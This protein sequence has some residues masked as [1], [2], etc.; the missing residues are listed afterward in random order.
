LSCEASVKRA[1]SLDATFFALA[2]PTRRAILARLT[3]GEASVNELAEPFQ[4]S[5]PAISSWGGLDW[6]CRRRAPSARGATN[7][8]PNQESRDDNNRKSEGYAAQ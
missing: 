1:L 8:E 2:D 5:Q 7:A 3:N 6:S 4:I